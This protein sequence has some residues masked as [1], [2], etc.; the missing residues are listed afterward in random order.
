MADVSGS[1]QHDEF[2]HYL[3][4]VGREGEPN[5][6]EMADALEHVAGMLV[7]KQIHGQYTAAWQANLIVFSFS[8]HWLWRCVAECDR[9]KQLLQAGLIQV[10]GSIHF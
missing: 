7:E 3:S 5:S 8:S 1:E 4:G 9:L 6:L 2:Y 10:A